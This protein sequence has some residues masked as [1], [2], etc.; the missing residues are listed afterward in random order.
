MISWYDTLRNRL[1]G[2]VGVAL[3]LLAFFWAGYG[4][5]AMVVQLF[6]S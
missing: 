3:L 2:G 1:R 5:M 4:F 6:R